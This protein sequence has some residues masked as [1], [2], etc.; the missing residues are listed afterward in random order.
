MV[1]QGDPRMG[2]GEATGN[3]RM[4]FAQI[5]AAL[6]TIETALKNPQCSLSGK[7]GYVSDTCSVN[8]YFDHQPYDKKPETRWKYQG[9]LTRFDR[10]ND[11]LEV[12]AADGQRH[13]LFFDTDN[14]FALRLA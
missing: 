11:V 3:E 7:A 4:D 13:V 10:K 5:E 2:P 8:V 12:I 1:R 9:K 6:N 14:V